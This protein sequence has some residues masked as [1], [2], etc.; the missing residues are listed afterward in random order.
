MSLADP[1]GT[2]TNDRGETLTFHCVQCRTP[3]RM[4]DQH[5]TLCRFC[6]LLGTS[7]QYESLQKKINGVGL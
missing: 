6:C 2:Y 7:T 1:K 5:P 4:G 3:L